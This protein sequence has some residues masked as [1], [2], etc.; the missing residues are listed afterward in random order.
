[1]FDNYRREQIEPLSPWAYFGYSLL[2]NIPIVGIICLLIFS[3]DDSN[4][5]RRNFAR[6]YW[7]IYVVIAVLALIT[8]LTGGGILVSLLALLS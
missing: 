4:I 7:C 3:F 2:F 8:I 1:M 6:S 5:N